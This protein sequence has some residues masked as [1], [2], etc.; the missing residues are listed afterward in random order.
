MLVNWVNGLRIN[1][2]VFGLIKRS[3]SQNRCQ[4]GGRAI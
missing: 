4:E 2:F 1:V 3:D